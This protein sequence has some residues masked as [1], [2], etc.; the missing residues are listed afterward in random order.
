MSFDG[1]ALDGRV[2]LVTGAGGPE[3]IGFAAARTLASR[4]ARVA[5]TATT[6]PI[7]ERAA[8]LGA[9][10]VVADAHR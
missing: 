7:H 4:D 9:L 6:G 5:I 8:E 2:A 10:G 1:I 3:G